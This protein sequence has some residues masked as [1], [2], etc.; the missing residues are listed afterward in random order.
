MGLPIAIVGIESDT[1]DEP[2]PSSRHRGE[3]TLHF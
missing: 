2:P 1:E 3:D